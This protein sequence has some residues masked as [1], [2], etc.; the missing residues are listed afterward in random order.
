MVLARIDRL[1]FGTADPKAG[2]AGSLMNVCADPRLN[3][4]VEVAAGL[5]ADECGALLKEF[6]R[7]RRGA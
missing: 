1:V 2:A 6:F 3:H 7:S 5:R 4:R